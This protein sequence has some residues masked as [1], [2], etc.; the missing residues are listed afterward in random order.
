MLRSLLLLLFVAAALAKNTPS[1][2]PEGRFNA[3]FVPNHASPFSLKNTVRNRCLSVKRDK[4]DTYWYLSVVDC[5][6]S[7]VDSFKWLHGENL[8]NML[9]WVTPG[10]KK[11][12][13]VKSGNQVHLGSCGKNTMQFAMTKSDAQGRFRV[14]DPESGLCLSTNV[15]RKLRLKPCHGKSTKWTIV[16]TIEK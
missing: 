8:L 9:Q 15:M 3:D 7:A 11:M 12:C 5:N 16:P 4:K 2:D 1:D 10:G 14:R 6:E 13:A